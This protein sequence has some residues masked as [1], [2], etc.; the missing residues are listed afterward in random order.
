[1]EENMGRRVLQTSTAQGVGDET[2]SRSGNAD[3]SLIYW[4]LEQKNT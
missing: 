1:M 4:P 2:F 3:R